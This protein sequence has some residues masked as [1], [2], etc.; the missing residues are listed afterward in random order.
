[1]IRNLVL[2]ASIVAASRA[3]FAFDV[4]VFPPRI[5]GDV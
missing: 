5:I 2:A 3:A 1:M 4:P